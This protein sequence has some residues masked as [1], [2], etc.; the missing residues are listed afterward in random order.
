MKMNTGI[1]I[2][3]R[4]YLI[5]KLIR[6]GMSIKALSTKLDMPEK[7]ITQICVEQKEKLYNGDYDIPEIDT[8]CRIMNI[9]DRERNIL[10]SILRNYGYTSLDD[11]WVYTD[12]DVFKTMPRI[13]RTFASIIWLA[14]HM[15]VE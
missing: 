1:D 13:G 6:K 11:S 14:Q 8:M 9:R 10:Q 2:D 15:K 4:D 3:Q 12:I 7:Q 5:Y